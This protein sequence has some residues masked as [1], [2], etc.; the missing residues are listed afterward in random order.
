[1][2]SIRRKIEAIAGPATETLA[3]GHARLLVRVR[4]HDDDSEHPQPDVLCDLRPS[5]PASWAS[6]SSP[7]P[8]TPTG[9]QTNASDTR[10]R[11]HHDQHQA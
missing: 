6:A 2:S 10:P 8:S 4:M 11:S 1:V 9:S 5:T 7:R 3:G